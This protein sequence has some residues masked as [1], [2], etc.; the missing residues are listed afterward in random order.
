MPPSGSKYERG[1]GNCSDR[2]IGRVPRGHRTWMGYPRECQ[3]R[4]S[5]GA[6]S[7]P[8]VTGRRRPTSGCGDG[9]LPRSGKAGSRD[10]V[11]SDREG[12]LALFD[13][14]SD[15]VRPFSASGGCVGFGWRDRVALARKGHG[16]PSRHARSGRLCTDEADRHL[17]TSLR[18][19]T[20]V[21][22]R[23]RSPQ[24]RPGFVAGS[25][26]E[27]MSRL[28]PLLF[29]SPQTR[30]RQPSFPLRSPSGGPQPLSSRSTFEIDRNGFAAPLQPV[31]YR[32]ECS[33]LTEN[34]GMNQVLWHCP[35]SW[36]SC[37]IRR[38]AR[39]NG[40]GRLSQPSNSPRYA[41][42]SFGLAS[43]ASAESAMTIRPVWIT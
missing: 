18:R 13:R 16:G 41:S 43:M 9:S 1:L 40:V 34:Y 23:R 8:G 15:V 39:D 5:S 21:A 36:R 29:S 27:T 30:F 35:G 31:S 28:L 14:P 4:I 42:R 24:H 22:S 20:P 37:R 33:G 11:D 25:G 6:R 2:G 26:S 7:S 17:S 19:E 12:W 3:R 32:A 10:C 38:P